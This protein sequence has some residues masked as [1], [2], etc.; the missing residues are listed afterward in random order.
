NGGAD[1]PNELYGGTGND[2]YI[3]EHRSDSIVELA[4]EGIDTVLTAL[5]QV[6]LSANVEN[7]TYTGTGTFTGVGNAIGNTIRGGAQRDVLLGQGGNDI[8]IGGTGAANELYGGE[9]DDYYILQV[10]DTVI[11]GAGAGNDTV[12]A[13]ISTYTLGANIENLIYGGSGNF[14]G[15]GNSLNNLIVGGAGNDVLRGGGGND[16]IQGGEGSDTV[17]LAGIA[18]QYTI[19]VE[20]MGYRVVDNTAGRDGSLLLTSIETLR[21]SDGSTQTLTAPAP[22]APEAQTL[23]GKDIYGDAFVMPALEDDLFVL[24]ALTDKGVEAGPQVQP[25]VVDKA[26]DSGIQVQPVLVDKGVDAEA[27][28]QVQPV[29]HDDF[30]VLGVEGPQVLPGLSDEEIALLG[31]GIVSLPAGLLEEANPLVVQGPHGLHLLQA[32]HTPDGHNAYDPWA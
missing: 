18:S 14:T 29:T 12:D 21:F 28:P 9:G 6:N 8:L 32:D 13:R 7:L 15:T 4:G 23:T 25:T 3:V 11:E 20:G 26:F 16:T 17:L 2:T 19:T 1:V 27:G 5:F 10:A 31:T 22:G 30:I 24:P